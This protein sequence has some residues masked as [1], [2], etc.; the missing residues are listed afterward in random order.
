MIIAIVITVLVMIC[1]YLFMSV[2]A[3]SNRLDTTSNELSEK[4]KSLETERHQ[5]GLLERYNDKLKAANGIL[6]AENKA[7]NQVIKDLQN[8]RKE[9]K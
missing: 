7:L 6:I 8:N 3:A 2:L 9:S 1:I 4:Q 5:N